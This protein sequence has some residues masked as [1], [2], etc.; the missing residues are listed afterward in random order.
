[1]YAIVFHAHQKIDRTARRHLRQLLAGDVFFPGSRSI[2]YFEGRKG[3]DAAK[4]KKTPQ[5]QPWHFVDPYDDSDNELNRLIDLHYHELV[6]ALAK[7][8]LV[9]SSFE[10]S[11]LA[12]AIVDGLT[13]AHHYPYEQELS[14]LRGE[15]RH[16]RIGLVG[17]AFVKGDTMLQ[18]LQ[19]SLKLV[20]PKGLLTTHA[21]FEA[22]AWAIMWPLRL[23]RA[24]PSEDEL[25]KLAD[26]DIVQLFRQAAREI[27]E[28]N[29][30]GRFMQRGWTVSNSR[31]VRRELAPRMVR[32]VTLAWYA[33]A[34]EAQAMKSELQP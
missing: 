11:W 4:L 25:S 19:R 32:M 22:G 21:L 15:D 20:G 33:A 14:R 27:A 16:T 30:Y 7:D 9:R 34:R 29:I 24:L 31:L 3:P 13:P 2:V 17:R 26:Y 6:D 12:H 8:D 18:S 23:T 1:M 5:D 10:A 28:L